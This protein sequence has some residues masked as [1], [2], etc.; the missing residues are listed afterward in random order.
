MSA[1]KFY[2]ITVRPFAEALPFV[3]DAV[4]LGGL[5][6]EEVI[7]LTGGYLGTIRRGS[8]SSIAVPAS[9]VG[10]SSNETGESAEYRPT[11]KFFKNHKPDLT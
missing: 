4:Q 3:G 10:W 1:S 11:K 2:V 7:S 6:L 8:I 5:D 9:E